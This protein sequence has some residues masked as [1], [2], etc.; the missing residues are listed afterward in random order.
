M[1]EL[2]EYAN[3]DL[4]VNKIPAKWGLKPEVT[5]VEVGAVLTKAAVTEAERSWETK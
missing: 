1:E 2:Q 5:V 4:W 3:S